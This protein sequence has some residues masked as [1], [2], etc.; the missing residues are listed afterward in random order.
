LVIEEVRYDFEEFRRYADD[1]IHD[2]I[3]LMIISKMNSTFKNISSREYF[4]NLIQQING[5]EAYVVRYGQPILYT[6]YR[7]MEFSDQKVTSQFVRLNDHSIDITMESVVGEF[8]KSFDSLV[9]TTAN[10]V[11]WG[12]DGGKSSRIDPLFKLLDSFV[13]AVHNLTLLEKNND[14]SLMGK[15]FSIRNINITKQSTHLEFLVDGQVNIIGL[16]PSQKK[17]GVE[18]LFGN[19]SIANTIV[20]L[21][22]Q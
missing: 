16:Y 12:T 19:S 17:D 4:V 3:K 7:G 22:K 15:R 21:M 20:S 9:S 11:N 2:L 18:I 8:I 6:K 10:R 5:C 14:D 13:H 1:F